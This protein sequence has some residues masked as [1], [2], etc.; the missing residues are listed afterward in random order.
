MLVVGAGPTGLGAAWRLDEIGHEQGSDLDWMLVEGAAVVGGMARS[1]SVDGYVWDVGGHVLFPHYQYFDDLLDELIDDWVHVTPV[2][3]AWMWGRFVPYP[4]QRN[5][6][7]FPAELRERI[8]GELGRPADG[9]IASFQDFLRMQ[10]GDSLYE[11]FFLPLNL[12]MWAAHP[13]RM[14]WGWADH[15]SGSAAANVPLIDVEELRADIEAGRDAPAWD[16]DTKIR[17]PAVG[18]TG[19]IWRQLSARLPADRLRLDTP[20][21]SIHAG[22]RMVEL[23]SAEWVSYD[24]LITSMPLDR[25]VRMVV[26]RPELGRFAD[27]LRPAAVEVVGV[28]LSGYPPGCLREICSLY[29]PDP[30]V[31]FW[32]VTVPS[33]YSAACVPDVG[34][35]WSLLCEVNVGDDRGAPLGSTIE[36]VLDGLVRLGFVRRTD[37]ERVWHRSIDHGYPVPL[38]ET[39]SVL[40]ELDAELGGLGIASRGRFGGWRYQVS[41]QDHAFMQGL[42]AV[43]RIMCGSDETTYPNEVS[44]RYEDGR[45][46]PAN[47]ERTSVRSHR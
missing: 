34:P 1:E 20:V 22:A 14:A 15:R 9:R 17:Y 6:G 11:E 23:C 21:T 24:H 10:F 40:D 31:A 28:G 47:M 27:V 33:N 46:R 7:R 18:G 4:V 42:E 38:L 26:D 29:I 19:E 44:I 35:H 12:K 41:N 16:S 8:L 25:L 32:R 43:D 37:V 2:R 13:A 5:L 39:E 3:G 45:S 36:A 30:D